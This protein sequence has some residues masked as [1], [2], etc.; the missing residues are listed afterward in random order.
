MGSFGQVTPTEIFIGPAPEAPEMIWAL[1]GSYLKQH[2]NTIYLRHPRDNSARFD[3]AGTLETNLIIEDFV[4]Q[5][6]RESGRL[7]VLCGTES[8]AL[9]NLAQAENVRVRS[10]L[11]NMPEYRDA[12]SL[13]ARHGVAL[14]HSK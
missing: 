7:F 5:H 9:I 8:S 1:I 11:P 10:I 14:I 4:L 2:P 3:F 6:T 13:M 12:R